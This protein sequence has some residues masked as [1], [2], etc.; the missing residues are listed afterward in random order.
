MELLERERESLG[1]RVRL[2]E[3]EKKEMAGEHKT[4]ELELSSQLD[5]LR[6]HVS[7]VEEAE[8]EKTES[9]VALRK[10]MEAVAVSKNNELTHLQEIHRYVIFSLSNTRS[11]SQ[12]QSF[13]G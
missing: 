6:G 5:Q 10:K 9:L 8:R 13:S 11:H 4:R 1:E 3:A 2:A 7:R 12:T